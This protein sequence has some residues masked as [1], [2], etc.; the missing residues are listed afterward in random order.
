VRVNQVLKKNRRIRQPLSILNAAP[1]IW[2]K[3]SQQIG[4]VQRAWY[5]NIA[6]P[7]LLYALPL[8]F[9]IWFVI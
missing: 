1:A 3:E 5:L 7:L 9:S 6:D 2:Y 4:P 8:F